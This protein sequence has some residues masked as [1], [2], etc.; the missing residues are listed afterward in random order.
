MRLL[1]AGWTPE[2]TPPGTRPYKDY[3]GGW[4]YTGEAIRSM[5][6]ETPYGLI[7]AK[8]PPQEV[9]QFIMA[10]GQPDAE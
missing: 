6:W 7:Y 1:A 3:D 4:T 2:D 5:V 10:V 9:L 8:D